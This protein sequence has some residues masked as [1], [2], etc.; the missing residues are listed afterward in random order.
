MITGRTPMRPRKDVP[1]TIALG[2]DRIGNPF[3]GHDEKN[4][5]ISAHDPSAAIGA[6]ADCDDQAR[7]RRQIRP[8]RAI[9]VLIYINC[10]QLS[11]D[12]NHS[13]MFT[14]LIDRPKRPTGRC[15]HRAIT[16]GS[17]N[18]IRFRAP[19]ARRLGEPDS[20]GLR[21]LKTRIPAIWRASPP[22]S[23]WRGSI[24]SSGRPASSATFCRA[25]DA[26]RVTVFEAAADDEALVAPPQPHRSSTSRRATA[27]EFDAGD[28]SALAI[29]CTADADEIKIAPQSRTAVTLAR[30][31]LRLEHRQ[32]RAGSRPS[33]RESPPRPI[34]AEAIPCPS[35]DRRDVFGA[36][37]AS[38]T[39]SCRQAR[40]A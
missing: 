5:P 17:K 8:S 28:G 24:M 29:A 27:A 32:L 18:E 33:A 38:L 23:P 14:T 6:G 39:S 19:Y 31:P 21:D 4:R 7:P 34:D 26:C 10:E 30:T 9:G 15:S 20:A 13:A 35:N 12:V 2:C 25:P 40:T 16:K 22:T 1:A 36:A 11:C 37:A 3:F